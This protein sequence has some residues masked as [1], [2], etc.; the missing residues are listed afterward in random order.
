MVVPYNRRPHHSGRPL[1]RGHREADRRLT[2][3]TRKTRF[4]N[5]SFGGNI[6]YVVITSR[7]LASLRDEREDFVLCVYISPLR[8]EIAAKMDADR[9]Q[10]FHGPMAQGSSQS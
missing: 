7:K 1:F 6:Q 8:I 9:R 2:K 3:A 5:T 10:W 4:T